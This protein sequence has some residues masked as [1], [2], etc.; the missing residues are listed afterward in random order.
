MAL[1]ASLT[2]WD[3]PSTSVEGA[4][5]Y[6]RLSKVGP[7][8]DCGTFVM[9]VLQAMSI[10]TTYLQPRD[11]GSSR[12]ASKQSESHRCLCGLKMTDSALQARVPRYLRL[13]DFHSRMDEGPPSTRIS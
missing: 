4:K 2:A 12:S 3:A 9:M 11:V 10:A 7:A 8:L 13:S 6:D 5:R 1:V